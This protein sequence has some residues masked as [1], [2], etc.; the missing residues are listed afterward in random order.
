ML[1]FKLPGYLEQQL[2]I[3]S[4][5]LPRSLI[6]KLKSKYDLRIISDKVYLK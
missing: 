1:I 4:L 3:R 5:F 6:E 2:N